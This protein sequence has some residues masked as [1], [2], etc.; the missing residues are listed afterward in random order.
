M[1]LPVY[2]RQVTIPWAANGIARISFAG[3]C[4]AALG[5]ADYLSIAAQFHTLII[6]AIP[7]LPLSAK[8]EA[9]RFITLI[10]SLYES[11][12]RL[13]CFAAATQ[14]HLFFPEAANADISDSLEEEALS[15]TLMEPYRPNVSI[16]SEELQEPS[17]EDLPKPSERREVLTADEN[18]PSADIAAFK[19]LAIFSGASSTFRYVAL[20]RRAGQD[21]R[22]AF[23]RAVS[24][25]HEMTSVEYWSSAQH[26]P[27]PSR[28]WE[29]RFE[30]PQL[31]DS[32][33]L[34][35][36]PQQP[37]DS[38][39]APKFNATHFWGFSPWAANR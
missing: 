18:H 21:E 12:V 3:L 20:T 37:D 16:Y 15:E 26:T 28:P 4:G 24:R 17:T 33:T 27:L 22:F 23:R 2:G 14:D 34:S 8:N 31:P 36:E 39:E 29:Q 35:D 25:I 38:S 11:K 7:V 1:E 32:P 30:A 10:D 5:P 6:D 19:N 13:V 9:R